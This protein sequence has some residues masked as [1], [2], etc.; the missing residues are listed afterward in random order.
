MCI[1]CCYLLCVEVLAI[2]F[3]LSPLTQGLLRFF[4][5]VPS[6]P[7]DAGVDQIDLKNRGI[8]S[9][10]FRLPL[11]IR[12]LTSEVFPF[13]SDTQPYA[14]RKKKQISR[15]AFT[16]VSGFSLLKRPRPGPGF[17]TAD[18]LAGETADGVVRP[19]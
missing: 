1:F 17:S 5:Y 2:V 12:G 6:V 11:E 10:R 7:P 14:T 4:P 8:P 18:N 9:I 13:W 15:F 19:C 16:G 3:R